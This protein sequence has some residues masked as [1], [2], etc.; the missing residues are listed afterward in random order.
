MAPSVAGI[1]GNGLLP[2]IASAPGYSRE[3]NSVSTPPT[4]V[5]PF[6]DRHSPNQATDGLQR[7]DSSGGMSLALSTGRSSRPLV[8]GAGSCSGASGSRS[9]GVAM[10]KLTKCF[11]SLAVL[12]L[13]FASEPSHAFFGQPMVGPSTSVSVRVAVSQPQP[14]YR[15]MPM[16]YGGGCGGRCGGGMIGGGSHGYGGGYGSYGYGYGYGYGSGYGSGY[17]YGYGYM[18][19]RQQGGCHGRTHRGF[20]CGHRGV[21]FCGGGR[22]R[23]KSF[24]LSL[25]IGG[26]HLGIQ[27]VSF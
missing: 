7:L 9:E 20:R 22:R 21:K 4:P 16:P 23:F 18:Q 26:F 14:I 27:K 6:F 10:K 25:G 15:P 13:A 11:S 5:V 17:G 3:C 8:G 12:V 1:S 2:A 19:P 24:S